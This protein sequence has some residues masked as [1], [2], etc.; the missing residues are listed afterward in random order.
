MDWIT[1]L[2]R[3]I[4]KYAVPRLMI[5]IIALYAAGYVIHI[6][7]PNFYGAYLAMNAQAIFEGQVWRI[8]TFMMQPPSANIL[9]G[10]IM[11][12]LYYSI[13][14]SLEAVWGSFRFNLYILGG[15]VLHIIAAILVYLMFGLNMPLGTQYLNLSLFFAYAMLYPDSM[16]YLWGIVPLKAKYLA[17]IDGC[18]FGYAILQAFLPAYGGSIFGII[19]KANALAAAVSVANF[20]IFYFSS[21][22]FKPYRPS[23]SQL[24]RKRE[25]KRSIKEAKPVKRP[26]GDGSLHRC[27]TCGRTEIDDPN[28]E[29][30]YCSKCNGNYEYCQDHLFTHEHIK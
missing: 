15:V 25:F 18:Y 8:V 5:Y 11:L 28:L 6:I 14:M 16:I 27:A 3:K 13:G 1:K 4:G 7:N 9:L 22:T 21:R 30:R 26:S 19:Y 23:A 29:F 17:I 12:F 10:V 24:K 2:E 20:A